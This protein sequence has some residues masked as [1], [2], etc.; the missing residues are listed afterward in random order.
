M[1][2][3][4]FNFSAEYFSNLWPVDFM[5]IH[6]GS[7]IWEHVLLVL[8]LADAWDYE[9]HLAI[10]YA[11]GGMKLAFNASIDNIWGG[12]D[13]VLHGDVSPRV[14]AAVTFSIK[15]CFRVHVFCGLRSDSYH[16]KYKSCVENRKYLW[17]DSWWF[18]LLLFFSYFRFFGRE[19]LAWFL[20]SSLV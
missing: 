7:K 18:Y 10:E 1:K 16:L 13:L 2:I 9:F 6:T 20:W 8:L 3:Q 4:S 12:R 19:Y 14:A 15:S 17:L 11:K 5:E